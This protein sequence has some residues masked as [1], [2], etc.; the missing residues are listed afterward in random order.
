MSTSLTCDLALPR[1]RKIGPVWFLLGNHLFY[2]SPTGIIGATKNQS[3]AAVIL[4]GIF[5]KASGQPIDSFLQ[6]LP[7]LP[8]L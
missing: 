5:E 4:A 3:L 2:E 1:P 7:E 8:H 6:W